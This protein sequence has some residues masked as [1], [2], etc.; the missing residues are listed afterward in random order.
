MDYQTKNL[1][2][3]NLYKKIFEKT[4]DA[5]LI[6]DDSGR[7]LEVN[8][9]ACELLQYTETELLK[10]SVWDITPEPNKE[11][12][13]E[14]WKKFMDI[15][16][17]EG[18]Y[19]VRRKDG[20]LVSTSFRAIANIADNR[21]ISVLRDITEKVESGRKLYDSN[22]HFNNI[23][24]S[25]SDAFFS[26]DADMKFTYF[27]NEAERIL[28]RKRDDVVGKHFREAFPEAVGSV[29]YNN[30][31]RAISERITLEFEE[32]FGIAPYENWYAVRVYPYYDGISIYFQTISDKK[33]AETRLKESEERYRQ[34]VES[35]PDAII[36]H[37][38]GKV[39]F[40]NK[41]SFILMKDNYCD[42]LIGTSIHEILHPD[43][44]GIA[45]ERIAKL[46][47][48]KY[49][50][51]PV[52]YKL[53]RFDD[54]YF[55]AEVSAASVKYK[56]DKAVQLIARD[57]T[58][59]KKIEN[60]IFEN[61]NATINLLEDLTVEIEERKKSEA[62]L[63]ESEERF[64]E[65]VNTISSGVA[66]YQVQN[67]GSSGSDYIIKD[68]NKS[69][70]QMER[71]EKNQVVGNSLKDIRPNIDEYGLIPILK[72]VWET[73]QSE[74]VPAKQYVDEKYSN[75]YENRVFKLPNGE[76]VAVYD[77]V[78]QRE[79]A[80]NALIQSEKKYR[81]VVENSPV[82]IFQTT[83]TGKVTMAN[84]SIAKM[85]DFDSGEDALLYYTDKNLGDH[86][87]ADKKRREEFIEL[88]KEK[89]IVENFVYE[90][91]THKGI[92]KIFNMNAV[93]NDNNIIEGFTED[94][95]EKIKGEEEVKINLTKYKTLF[96]SMP[97]GITV[98]DIA[99]K[100]IESNLEAEKLLGI[101]KEEHETRSIDSEDWQ[102]IRPDGTKM[103]NIE[104]PSVRALKEN[105]TISNVVM[106][107]KKRDSNITWLNVTAAP[108]PLSGYGVLISY[109]DITERIKAEE[110][111]KE[112][113]T[114]FDAFM[115]HLPGATF[116]KDA[117]NKLIFCNRTY[118]AMV[119]STPKEL[120]SR[121]Q[122]DK[123]PPALAKQ[124]YRENVA[125]IDNG[126]ILISETTYPGKET[127][128]DWMT[129]KFPIDIKGNKRLLGAIS[130]E[131][132]EKKKSEK[133]LRE[134]EEKYRTL[135]ENMTEGVFY[136]DK[137][138]RLIDANNSALQLFGLTEDQ[139]Y[140]RTSFHPDWKVI[141]KAGNVLAPE[142]HPSMVALSK[143]EKV[144]DCEIA[145]YN[146][147]T[148][149]NV[150]LLV[151][152]T[153]QYY[154]SDKKPSQVFVTL[155][156]ITER[157]LA[158][159]E[160]KNKNDFIETVLDNLPIGIALNRVDAGDA[161]YINK[162]FEE[163]YGW[164]ADE[165]KD[166][167]GFFKKVYPDDEYRN[168][169]M[170][171]VVADIQSG[172]AA[173]M[174]WENC[175]VTQKDGTNK[176]INA[177]NIP[178]FEQNTMVSTVI[179]VTAQKKAEESLRDSEELF[180][181]L[182]DQAAVGVA[183]VAPNGKF[184]MI[185]KKI[186]EITGYTYDEIM[187]LT[188]KELTHPE[189]IYLDDKQSE[190]VMQDRINAFEIEKR[191]K[192]KKGHYIW[193]KLFSQVVRDEFRKPQ[194]AI[195]V[196][197]DI[198]ETKNYEKALSEAEELKTLILDSTA[199]AFTYYDKDMIVRLCNQATANILKKDINKIIGQKCYQIFYGCDKP[200][201]T[202]HIK[203]VITNGKPK[204]FEKAWEKTG[205]EYNIRVY[206]IFDTN[207]NILGAAEF[208]LDIT[209]KIK[210]QRL[211]EES[212]RRYRTL[213]ENMR[214]GFIATDLKG[215]IINCNKALEKMLGYTIDELNKITYKKITPRKWYAFENEIVE[216]KVLN[217]GYSGLYEKE[218]IHKNGSVFPVE[219]G[220]YPI[221]DYDDRVVGMWGMVRDISERKKIEEALKES[222]EKFRSLVESMDDVIY[223]LDKN[224]KHTGLFGRWLT[225][226]N[227]DTELFI[228]KTAAEIF[229]EKE[230]QCHIVAN[231]KALRGRNVVYEWSGQFE[232]GIQ[233]Y[234]TSLSPLRNSAKKV[235]GIVGVAR[236][237]TELKNAEIAIAESE[238]KYRNLYNNIPVGVFRSK[239]SGE[240]VS[241][242]PQM[243]K[244]YGYSSMKE[245][246]KQPAEKF[247]YEVSDRNKI[248]KLLKEKESIHG[249]ITKEIKKDNSQIWIKSNYTSIK[250]ENG[251]IKYLDGVVEDVSVQIE[252]EAALK[253]SEKKFRTLFNHAVDMIFLF[254][255]DG[256]IVDV[257]E[258]VI[259][260]YE[261]S[262]DSILSMHM[263]DF[264]PDFDIKGGVKYLL[265][266]FKSASSYSFE[267]SLFD[268][269]GDVFPVDVSIGL[270]EME[271]K[272]YFLTMIRDITDRK[273]TE[274]EI[275]ESRKQFQKLTMYLQDVREEERKK[276]S[277]EI[278]DDLGQKLTAIKIDVAWLRQRLTQNPALLSS[279]IDSIYQLVDETIYTVQD[280]SVRL[281]PS[282]LDD[283][284]LI[285][286]IDWQ[287]DDF[288]SRTGIKC[289]KELMP[290]HYNFSK[291]MATTIFRI[292][293]ESLTNVA[294]HAKAKNI[295][296]TLKE[297]NNK[298]IL[299]IRDNG[300][301]ISQDE[302]SNS[303]S[304][305]LMGMKERAAVFG[306][307]LTIEG[308]KGK[309]TVVKLL[310][311]SEFIGK[312]ND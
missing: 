4:Q 39:V 10:M 176:I 147:S 71:M 86:L 115:N 42:R 198:T 252:T 242:N 228:G 279:K 238:A 104:F 218:Y 214:D 118:A 233:Y 121:S 33:N 179:D 137:T 298:L 100:I 2:N 311:P 81:H 253:E 67:E 91:V 300:K 130:L 173:R 281:R 8:N 285:P 220:V 87:Y 221:K 240:I 270:I 206:P 261:S 229:G 260:Q 152:A 199:E 256:N 254:D 44:A 105:Q 41:K 32:Y 122:Y 66:I 170:T 150:W 286:A 113:E 143:G 68:F 123:I 283:L 209:D 17:L 40:A 167:S 216:N 307:S 259:K 177:V 274:I 183:Q 142:E 172:D 25:I 203:E 52:E 277:L 146:P 31:S 114:R 108:I 141:D 295:S 139:F 190:L 136:Q 201:K 82:G 180:R 219:L 226:Q 207:G 237:I 78:T 124:Y 60:E 225:K 21:H 12:G 296:V 230:G 144:I 15:G 65:L 276:I 236:D 51:N 111:L 166:I 165:M 112:S 248:I 175:K 24:E 239:P 235:I 22:K 9:A 48:G 204:V 265:S 103:P 73:G 202:C 85:L 135:F 309:G 294:R 55:I 74:Y 168:E 160:I 34:L 288:Q 205:R 273:K 245:F 128:T 94:I 90:A 50:Q 189:D 192:H 291:E 184:M 125:V 153:P 251:K 102:L 155:K 187:N 268:K 255:L 162:K 290:E 182:F 96:D 280:L 133:A 99:G 287:L 97:A 243:Y 119:G 76:I 27:N 140:G 215:K 163:V 127:N 305:G 188:F 292:I 38:N 222:E 107:I 174:H 47:E 244:I 304:F 30:Y 46:M 148:K 246:L 129:I 1:G 83:M 231:K 26:L 308:K 93:L 110:G 92:R 302:I 138:G 145:V 212:E 249:I 64:R 77:D 241:I 289:T 195:A 57:I 14:M 169:L 109:F 157:K 3:E 284:G 106:G 258:T 278:H 131:I 299:I 49:V 5:I 126:E 297:K 164:P 72:K 70:L 250:D 61:H 186:L 269:N 191:Y 35:S 282:I 213:F 271:D 19:E 88:I 95:T 132:T 197:A 178:L 217:E 63:K 101:G 156:D 36:I 89:G 84:D 59:R 151:N 29:F 266:K 208:A 54:S 171:R 211:L 181:T 154:K 75:Y 234:Q 116:I 62:A 303:D 120:I 200:C 158:E 11:L 53:K 293:Q 196:I 58:D 80:Q 7:Y 149:E 37:Q 275:L 69:A 161:F 301:G 306:G 210:A 247:Y 28:G 193:I 6:A 264:Q 20:K 117:D 159:D 45:A 43:Y 310:L 194:Y 16:E 223:T 18:D 185:N 56:G 98:T 272:K 134:S 227:V 79:N 23:L 257:N 224:H 262:R 267:S 232:E 13:A 312:E 263:R